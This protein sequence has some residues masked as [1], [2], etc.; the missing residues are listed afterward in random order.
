MS[1]ATAWHHLGW[2]GALIL[3]GLAFVAGCALAVLVGSLRT[4]DWE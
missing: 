2:Q 1:I 4:R 3:A